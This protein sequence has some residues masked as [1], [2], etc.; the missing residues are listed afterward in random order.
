[1]SSSPPP[2]AVSRLVLGLGAL[3]FLHG[4]YSTYEHLALRKSLGLAADTSEAVPF[5]VRGCLHC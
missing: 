5:D 3:V 4:A 1:M 2:S